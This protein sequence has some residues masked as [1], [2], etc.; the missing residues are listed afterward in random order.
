VKAKVRL[1][2]ILFVCASTVYSFGQINCVPNVTTNLVCELASTAYLLSPGFDENSILPIISNNG[3]TNSYA[4]SAAIGT[5]LTQLPIPGSTVGV[6]SLR[7]KGS[8]IGVPFENLGP[9]LTDRSDTVGRGHLFV[10]FSYQHFNFNAID[11]QSMKSLPFAVTFNVTSNATSAG[12]FYG[13]EINNVSFQ[14]D[15]YV[16][17][18]TYGVT[19]RTDISVI[20]PFNSVSMKVETSGFQEYIGVPNSSG[21]TVYGVVAGIPTNNTVTT[22]G[23]ANGVGDVTFNMK[24]LL[25]GGEGDRTAIAA[26][27]SFRIPSGD[28]LNYLGSGAWGGNAYGLFEYRA[29]LTPHLKLSYLWNGVSILAISNQG[30]TDRLPGGI[31]YDAGADFKILRNLTFAADILGSEVIAAPSVVLSPISLPGAGATGSPPSSLPSLTLA[32]NPYTTVNF[33]TGLKWSPLPHFLVYGNVTM[34]ANNAG[35]R[36]DP[37]PLFGI[38][39]NLK[40]K[41]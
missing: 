8:D 23:S 34:Q 14:L 22:P 4:L 6:A 37:V 39:Y 40:A 5:Q 9:I 31:Q 38:A 29:R 21:G 24:Q 16:G 19:R 13:G 7:Q 30:T 17:M 33:S 2:V 18:L 12:Q 15:Q 32:I 11:G 26:G 36:S 35:L 10:G 28:A 41:R 1:L 25:I 3:N 20:V 27:A